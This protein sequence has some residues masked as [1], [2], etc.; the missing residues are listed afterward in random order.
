MTV[1]V[2]PTI[3]AGCIMRTTNKYFDFSLRQDFEGKRDLLLEELK[4]QEAKRAG[5]Q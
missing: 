5:V 4:G 3:A 2:Q 1:G